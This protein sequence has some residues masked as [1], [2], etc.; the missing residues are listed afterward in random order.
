LDKIQF[1]QTENLV[2]IR[3]I[4]KK[5]SLLDEKLKELQEVGDENQ[6]LFSD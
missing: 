6:I 5:I 4:D 3:E 2:K 1:I